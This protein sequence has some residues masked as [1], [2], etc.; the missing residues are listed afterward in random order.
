MKKSMR[1]RVWALAL[2]GILLCGMGS[3]VLAEEIEAP[4]VSAQEE[5]PDSILYYGQVQE[6]VK[7]GDGTASQLRMTSERYGEYTFNLSGE[8]VWIDS[9]NRCAANPAEIQENEGVYVFH[10]PAVT[11]SLP[12]QA[13]AFTVVRNLPMDVGCPMY[14]QVEAVSE[15]EGKLRITTDNGG[16]F[17]FADEETEFLPYLTKEA[18]GK[19]D[20]R[21]G[22]YIMAW[23]DTVAESYPGR[24]YARHIMVLPAKEAAEDTVLTRAGLVSLLHERAGKP[25]VNYAMRY[26][27]VDGIAEYAEAVRWATAEGLVSGYG[28]GCFGPEDTLNREQLAVILWRSAE[29]PVLMD[30]PGLAVYSDAG[31]IS[32]FA[33]QALAWAHQR[34]ALNWIVGEK[35]LPLEAVTRNEAAEMLKQLE[36]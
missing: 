36:L 11:A 33:R 9:G 25:V 6:L 5:L 23:Y 20:I 28:D 19:E 29:S 34:G 1:K 4:A 13:A 32:D 3:T 12:P 7:T 26:T 18:A 8:T 17:L 31:E 2:S 24:A 10:S 21:P 30:Y 14:H 15:N 27:D 16:L 35:L 22:N